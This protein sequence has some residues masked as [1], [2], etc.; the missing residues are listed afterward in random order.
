MTSRRKAIHEAA[1]T[2]GA[3]IESPLDRAILD[4]AIDEILPTKHRD[5]TESEAM[6]SAKNAVVDARHAL[7][8][9]KETC[10]EIERTEKKKC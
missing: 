3:R 10:E 5:P 8:S 9:T 4:V 7:E 1:K 2:L 6:N